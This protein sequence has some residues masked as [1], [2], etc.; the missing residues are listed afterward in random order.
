MTLRRTSLVVLFPFLVLVAGALSFTAPSS[1]A[2]EIGVED[3][4]AEP[5]LPASYLEAMPWR[6][7][8]PANMGGRIT[9]FAVNAKDSSMYWV[10][11]AS[12][13]LLKTVN[14]GISYEH[15]FDHEATVSIGDV[16]VAPSNPDIVWVGTGEANPRNSVSWG[17]GVYKSIDGGKTWEHMGLKESFQIG[18]IAIHPENPDVV[19]VGALGRLWGESEERG[20]YKTSDGGATW[21]KVLSVDERTGVV[22]VKMKPGDP[23]TLFVATYERQR[24]GFDT[25][26]PAKKWGP[27]SGLWR[28]SDG[29]ASWTRLTRGLP[30]GLLGRIGIDCSRAKPGVVYAVVESETISQEPENAAWLG[31]N[32]EDAEVGARI[33]EI[34]E[35]GPAERAGLQKGDI[36]LRVEDHAVLSFSDLLTEV[37]KRLAGTTVQMEI[38][39]NR[40]MEKIEVSFST[41][42]E[43]QEDAP[44]SPPEES[45]AGE[46][47]EK[48]TK[49]EP[50]DQRE[51]KPGPFTSG[52]GGQR[53]NVQ[54]QQGPDGHEYGGLYRSEDDGETWTRINSVNPRPM[55]YSQVRVDPSDDRY[56]YVLGTSLYRSKDG[57]ETFTADGAGRGVHVDHHALWIDPQDGRHIMLGNDGG[58][59]VTY[60][61]MEAWDH[62]NHVAI[63]QFYRVEVDWSPDYRVHGGLQDNGSWAGPSRVGNDP[64]PSN[65][66]WISTGGGDGFVCR[67]DRDDPDLVYVE[68]QNGGLLRRH[69]TRGEF[70]SLR[71]RPERGQAFRFNWN[72]PFMLSHHNTR[73]YY[74]AG[75]HVFR[76]LDRGDGIRPISP[77]IT[78]TDKGSATALSE[79]PIDSDILYVGTDDGA[80]FATRDGGSTW[81][82]LFAEVEPEPEEQ[83]EEKKPSRLVAAETGAEGGETASPTA[84]GEAASRRPAAGSAGRRGSGGPGA[85]RT[86]GGAGA[87]GPQGGPG[88]VQGG[89]RGGPAA[90]QAAG[91]R[92]GPARRGGAARRSPLVGLWEGD[93]RGAN[94]PEGQGSFTLDLVREEGG[95]LGG[96]LNAD[97]GDGPIS[98]VSFDPETRKLVF[99]FVTD[100]VSLKF[101]GDVEGDGMKGTIEAMGGFFRLEFTATRKAQGGEADADPARAGYEWKR[102]SELVPE[103]RWV[104]SLTASR[105]AKDR[106]YLTLDGHRSDDDELHLFVSEDSG[107]TWRSLRANL[108]EGAG[109]IRALV[110]D[111]RNPDLLYLGAELSAWVSIDRGGSWTRFGKSLPTV[112]VH[113]FAQHPTRGELVAATHGR[114]LWILDVTTLRQVT[115]Q[116]IAETAHL[117]TPGPAILWKNEPSVGSTL[118]RYVGENPPSGA[119]LSY[120]LGKKAARVKLSILD[121][122]GESVRDLEASLDPGLH[123]VEWDL[124]REMPPDQG[125]GGGPRR[126][127]R[128]APRVGPGSYVVAL[129]V[130]GTTFRQKLEVRIDPTDTDPTWLA[131]ERER[132]AL[133]EEIGDED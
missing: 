125:Q 69:L 41:R 43:E 42:P 54:E 1:A 124:R 49:E 11:T 93:A 117:Y 81:V 68:S 12:G 120:S 45:E 80:V 27:G 64:G 36:V 8:G 104:S 25:N 6:C 114:S 110:E 21:T 115:P 96:T 53:E 66:D 119:I 107:K 122:A 116:A 16:A 85:R 89:R 26:D 18:R 51:K 39:R 38:S 109:T 87:G 108:P 28:T 65:E 30:G 44:E 98:D 128:R 92:G 123:R 56:L 62:H 111:L 78:R 90:G 91:G 24:D 23:E 17:D 7:I 15:Q 73:I 3:A 112:S 130:D 48:A 22:D 102:L 46:E 106:V 9:G 127:F 70:A 77:E 61:R 58:I 60:D 5:S 71:P 129:T 14:N 29:G 86:G 118:R 132:E 97:V 55:Y 4:P 52:L 40:K 84:R 19:Y 72:T 82:D 34:T 20:L 131:N 88:N 67:I 32:G 50:E 79:S 63:G 47:E 95:E 13:G 37:R 31:A 83:E 33:T 75:N 76:S 35:K 94:V 2:E 57:G 100:V 103:P 113:D 121:L 126:R 59:Y 101:T 105:H 133:E 10:A 99:R 74:A